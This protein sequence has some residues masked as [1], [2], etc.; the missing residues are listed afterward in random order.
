[1]GDKLLEQRKSIA[2]LLKIIKNATDIYRILTA[3]L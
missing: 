2:F 1:M 3:L